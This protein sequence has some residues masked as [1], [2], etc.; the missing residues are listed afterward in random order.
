MLARVAPVREAPAVSQRADGQGVSFEVLPY[1][2]GPVGYA[3]NYFP[4]KAAV[5]IALLKTNAVILRAASP[6][7]NCARSELDAG[8][9]FGVEVLGDPYE[10]FAPGSISHPMRPALRYVITKQLKRQ[11]QQA[12][13][14]AYVSGGSLVRRYPSQRSAFTTTYSSIAVQDSAFAALPRTFSSPVQPLRIVSIGTLAVPYKGFDVLIDAVSACAKDRMGIQLVIVGEGRCR[15]SLKRHAQNCGVEQI[16]QFTGRVSAGEGVRDQ[17]DRADLFVL[18]SKT[19]GL[20]RAMIEAMARGLPCIGSAVG[21]IPDLLGPEELFPRGDAKS[22]ARKIREVCLDPERMTRLS[23]ENLAKAREYHD[24]ILSSR[25][26]QFFA[27][28]RDATWR[29]SQA[30]PRGA[31]DRGRTSENCSENET[32]RAVASR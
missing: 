1:Y 24:S 26:R 30:H 16:V 11:C 31:F 3:R 10:V 19:E 21:G 12:C 23:A 22:L 20:P 5:R 27:H 14:V 6:I 29:W 2:V 18:A 8:R 9:P 15:E 32:T 17:L 13:A 4:L 28:V 25:R 7:A